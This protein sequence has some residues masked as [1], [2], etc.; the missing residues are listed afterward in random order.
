[1]VMK[2]KQIRDE[3]F[4]E[5]LKYSNIDRIMLREVWNKAWAA[6]A[7]DTLNTLGDYA[8]AIAGTTPDPNYFDKAYVELKSYYERLGGDG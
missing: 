1:M 7:M 8:C 4:E 5:F 2:S 6:C 3:Q